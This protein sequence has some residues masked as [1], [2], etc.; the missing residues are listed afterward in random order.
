MSNAD[1]E[2]KFTAAPGAI[3]VV[4]APPLCGVCVHRSVG[5]VGW[6]CKA[7]PGG[8][9]EPILR[10]QA[11]HRRAYEG[12]GGVRFQ[13]RADTPAEAL[14]LIFRFLDAARPG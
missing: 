5:E 8:I 2:D 10:N 12:D 6:A 11:D 1:R 7:F 3:V 13:A 4:G 9:P 14:E